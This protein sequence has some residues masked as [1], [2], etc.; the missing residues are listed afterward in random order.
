MTIVTEIIQIDKG[1]HGAQ[2]DLIGENKREMMYLPR[3]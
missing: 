2:E 1:G 3:L